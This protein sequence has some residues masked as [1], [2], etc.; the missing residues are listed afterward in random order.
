CA[1]RLGSTSNQSNGP[2]YDRGGTGT[3]PVCSRD[4]KRRIG[5]VSKRSSLGVSLES[6]RRGVVHGLVTSKWVPLF[7]RGPML[8]AKAGPAYT[9]LRRRISSSGQ[10]NLV[11]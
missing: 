5:K 2:G 1:V 9:G 3:G 10:N 8:H 7:F 6:A 11:Y 4:F